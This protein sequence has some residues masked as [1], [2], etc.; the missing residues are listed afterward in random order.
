MNDLDEALDMSE[1]SVEFRTSMEA[2]E[3]D[4]EGSDIGPLEDGDNRARRKRKKL[5]PYILLS[6][7]SVS[8]SK[9]V[10]R[11]KRHLKPKAGLGF[12][13][14]ESRAKPFKTELKRREA[15]PSTANV[16]VRLRER[17][18][19]A[20]VDEED[21]EPSLERLEDR[22]EGDLKHDPPCPNCESRGLTC[23][24]PLGRLFGMRC[25][26]C[27]R[28]KKHCAYSKIRISSHPPDVSGEVEAAGGGEQEERGMKWAE[29][30]G[31]SFGRQLRSS[32]SRQRKITKRKVRDGR[33][34]YAL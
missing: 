19:S 2:I 30:V 21:E 12:K 5:E 17:P 23:F 24:A 13:P 28:I 7:P 6:S 31:G 32:T 14:S 22:Q 3:S 20:T 26:R 4:A 29:N 25:R 1:P 9:S 15:V 18:V 10:P 11:S 27:T 33:A 8:R 34:Y 16:N